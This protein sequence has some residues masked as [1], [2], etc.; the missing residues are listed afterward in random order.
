MLMAGGAD[1]LA[2]GGVGLPHPA[3]KVSNN[4]DEARVFI[5]MVSISTDGKWES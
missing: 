2:L 1:L 5:F 4:R 3:S